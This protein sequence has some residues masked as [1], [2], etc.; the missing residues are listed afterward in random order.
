ME[1]V[2]VCGSL[3][4]SLTVFAF[5][6]VTSLESLVHGEHDGEIK[7]RSPHKTAFISDGGGMESYGMESCGMESCGMESS[8]MESC[9]MESCG[10]ESSCTCHFLHTFTVIMH[11][12]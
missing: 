9:G 10:M 1:N 8:G 12:S 11:Y 4:S 2:C 7:A 3:A 5:A 6:L